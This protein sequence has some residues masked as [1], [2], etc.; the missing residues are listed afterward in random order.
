MEI[1][2]ISLE[3]ALYILAAL[4]TV[5][6]PMLTLVAYSLRKTKDPFLQFYVIA[7]LGISIIYWNIIAWNSGPDQIDMVQYMFGFFA[8]AGLLTII[9]RSIALY[10]FV[11]N[12]LKVK[13]PYGFNHQHT[14]FWPYFLL[15]IAW[16]LMTLWLTLYYTFNEANLQNRKGLFCYFVGFLFFCG[17]CRIAWHF[18]ETHAIAKLAV[19]EC[20][21]EKKIYGLL[22]AVDLDYK[23]TF[24]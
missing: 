18:I 11:R 7:I 13:K 14:N 17:V 8:V 2:I 5:V 1:K 21:I 10:F 3:Q 23:S 15:I 4:L 22:R 12:P 24:Y 16:V 6:S 19:D 9:W 20:S